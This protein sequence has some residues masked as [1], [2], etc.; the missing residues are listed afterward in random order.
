MI[1]L[2]IIPVLETKSGGVFILDIDV[3]RFLL[4]CVIPCSPSDWK[5][6]FEFEFPEDGPSRFGTK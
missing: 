5:W 3:K 2:F 4:C 6:N 1:P